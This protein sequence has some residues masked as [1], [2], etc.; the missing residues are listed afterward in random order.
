M[1][2]LHYMSDKVEIDKITKIFFGIFTN[3]NNKKPD[4]NIIY[5]VCIPE[6]ILIKKTGLTQEVY[7]LQSFI[8]PRK[9]LLSAGALTEFEE[10]ETAEETK[11]IGNIA[12][13]FSKYKKSGYLN[14]KYFE[15]YGNKSF[16]FIK[17]ADGWKINSLIWE[18][19]I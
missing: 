17:T 8:Q 12:Q 1:H 13:R 7:N 3:T 11:R 18:D 4:W 19:V 15:G 16:Q 6:T 10:M 5:T 14:G 2:I 9:E